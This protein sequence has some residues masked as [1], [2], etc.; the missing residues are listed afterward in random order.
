MKSKPVFMFLRRRYSRLV[1]VI[2]AFPP[3][4]EFVTFNPDG[5]LRIH[6]PRHTII[7]IINGPYNRHAP[8]VLPLA[9]QKDHE[10]S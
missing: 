8:G 10:F 9:G 1:F 5:F 2:S 7:T 6:Q 3:L 4:P